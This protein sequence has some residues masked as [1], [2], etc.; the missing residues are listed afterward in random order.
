MGSFHL[1]QHGDQRHLDLAEEAVEAGFGK[2]LLERLAGREGGQR[3]EADSHSGGNIA[4]GGQRYLEPFVGDVGDR[5]GP[6]RGIEQVCRNLGVEGHWKWLSRAAGDVRDRNRLGLV[7]D[8]PDAGLQQQ[9]S[10]PPDGIVALGDQHAA[11]AARQCESLRHA[12]HRSR[13]VH[14]QRGPDLVLAGQPCGRVRG[15]VFGGFEPFQERGIGDGRAQGRDQV[16]WTRC[17]ARD[18]GTRGGKRR[19]SDRLDKPGRSEVHRQLQPLAVSDQGAAVAAVA[20]RAPRGPGR[21][22]A[23]ARGAPCPSGNGPRS[24]RDPRRRH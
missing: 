19:S 12:T 3:V 11:V 6:E 10:Q 22:R 2:R 13:V 18:P 20:P 23:R 1:G 17:L 9:V 16:R 7:A 24:A 14:E 15:I 21:A 8:D 4:G 5:L